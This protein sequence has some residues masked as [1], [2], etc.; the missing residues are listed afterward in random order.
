MPGL[1]LVALVMCLAVQHQ[2]MAELLRVVSMVLGRCSSAGDSSMHEQCK[3]I[4][5]L[6]R[7]S[8]ETGSSGVALMASLSW[9]VISCRSSSQLTS[10]AL[11]SWT[12]SSLCN[13]SSRDLMLPDR[14]QCIECNK[15]QRT[16]KRVTA[17]Q[18]RA[19]V[20][21]RH[22]TPWRES[23]CAVDGGGPRSGSRDGDARPSRL[24]PVHEGV[25]PRR[26]R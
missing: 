15:Q 25:H 18:V 8:P 13:R 5:A 22:F 17:A 21:L 3:R 24:Q 14:N 2:A 16:G 4:R 9:P 19:C 6:W 26:F 11:M 1:L 7:T 20:I 23:C 12:F 10:S